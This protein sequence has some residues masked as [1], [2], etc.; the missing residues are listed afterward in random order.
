MS[1]HPSPGPSLAHS[2]NFHQPTPHSSR[3][4]PR[5]PIGIA[6][7]AEDVKYQAK[8]KELKRKVKDIEADNDNL[9]WK[10]LQ[11]KRNIQRMKLERSI[12]YERLAALPVSPADDRNVP[13]LHAAHGL[14]LPPPPRSSH[15]GRPL[16]DVREYP[17]GGDEHPLGDYSRPGAGQRVT[18]GSDY[19]LPMIDTSIAPGVAPPSRSISSSHHASRRGSAGS[20]QPLPPLPPPTHLPPVQHL[21]VPRAHSHSSHSSH[22]LSSPHLHHPSG[23]HE[24][25]S[26]P[27][28]S[29]SRDQLQTLTR[30]FSQGHSLHHYPEGLPSVQHV[31]HSPPLP[32]TERVRRHDVHELTG[33]PRD[34]HGH[35]RHQAPL[36]P[37]SPHHST[38]SRSGRPM[39]AH[40]RMGPGTYINRSDDYP[41]R[42]LDRD[43]D[44]ERERERGRE[45]H[46]RANELSSAHM[47]SPPQQRARHHTDYPDHHPTSRIRD[48]T[49]YYQDMSGP[50]VY[51]PVSRSGTP[52]SVGDDRPSRP[53]S[54]A[55]QHYYEQERSRSYK[56][57][58]V[59]PPNANEELDFVHEDGRGQRDRGGISGGGA[60]AP[61]PESRKR[62]RNDADGEND[63]VEGSAGSGGLQYSGGRL[64]EDRGS[65]RYHR[66]SHLGWAS[67]RQDEES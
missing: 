51:P 15:P 37:A 66:D 8:Y 38:D 55:G 26:H 9:H 44:W 22:S 50:G 6:A 63:I 43:R 35:T 4:K 28:S 5:P 18:S 16:R 25:A 30:S 24:R 67:D 1:R 29:H 7:G 31:L 33:S 13:S 47:H 53:D 48:D 40:Q 14:S 61:A 62:S 41:D 46:Q 10:V 36:I 57:R 56:L 45:H 65:K 11:A 42:D 12:L 64:P 58:P 21:D 52:V 54:R 23:S 60:F 49:G 3:Q 59:N 39:H 2:Q 27:H 19:H 32:E 20:I 17:H 34:P